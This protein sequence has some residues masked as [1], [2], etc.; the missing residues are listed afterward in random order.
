MK[1]TDKK[2]EHRT[3]ADRLQEAREKAGLSAEAMAQ[4]LD[5]PL[6]EYSQ[7]EAGTAQPDTETVGRVAKILHVTGNY[8]LF[9]LTREGMVGAMFP[10]K[11][12]PETLPGWYKG[13]MAGAA[14]LFCGGAGMLLLLFVR[15]A[16]EETGSLLSFLPFQVFLG[17]FAVG[18]VL[19]VISGILRSRDK[20]RKLLKEQRDHEEEPNK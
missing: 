13:I 2:E 1:D 5:V 15:R 14:L 3:L 7:W 20:K 19:C 12:V 17:M 6:E 10:N 9:G 4:Q 8:L 18:V 16:G 11:A